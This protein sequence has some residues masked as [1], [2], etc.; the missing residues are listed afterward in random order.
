MLN[1][2]KRFWQV[3]WAEQWQYRANL[4]MY[5]AY[6]LV[7]PIVYLSVWTTIANAQ[8]GVNGMSAGDFAAYY[9]VLLPVDIATAAITIHLFAYKIQDGTLSNSL[10]QP[11]HPVLVNTLVNTIAFKVLQL[12]IFVPI[13]I[14]LFL[15]FRPPLAISAES[16][17]L[18][19]PAL[20]LGFLINF[21][22]DST[23]TL[24][25]FW[26]TRVW[27][28]HQLYWAI[29]MMLGGSFVPLSLLPGLIQTVARFAPMQLWLYFPVQLLLNKLPPGDIAVNFVL[30]AFWLVVLFLVFRATWSAGLKKYSAVG[31]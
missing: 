30:Q 10:M 29:G 13:W 11:V 3:N 17:L 23:I 5:L 14:G 20:I 6:W 9:L 21:L 18:A 2:Y 31:A 15:I 27:S 4:F 12:I 25:A 28:I 7:S 16:L 24:I 1:I 8:G 26:T 22:V 19:I